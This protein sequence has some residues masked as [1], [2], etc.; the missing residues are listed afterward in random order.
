MNE[1]DFDWAFKVN[2]K[3]LSFNRMYLLGCLL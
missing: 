2:F 1:I 3:L